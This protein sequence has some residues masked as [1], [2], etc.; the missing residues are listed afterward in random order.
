MGFLP[1][2]LCL[3]SLLLK[4]IS[5]LDL[6][7]TLIQHDL[8]LTWLYLKKHI[9]KNVLILRLWVVQVDRELGG[10]GT[11]PS[12]TS[13]AVCTQMFLLIPTPTTWASLLAQLVKNSPTM[14]QTWVQSRGWE[15]PQEK[16][17]ATHSS[18]LSWRMPWTVSHRVAKSQTLLSDFH[19]HFP[20][21][22]AIYLSHKGE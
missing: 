19:F 12:T 16:G 4:R 15:D 9:S 8:I 6:R 3:P 18:I 11:I 1:W 10:G 21:Q 5:S 20:L 2:C 22:Y 14:R 7:L 17:K 13:W